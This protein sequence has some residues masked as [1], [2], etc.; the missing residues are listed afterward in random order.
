MRKECSSRME[1]IILEETRKWLSLFAANSSKHSQPAMSQ[2]KTIPLLQNP[3]PT[4]CSA[5]QPIMDLKVNEWRTSATEGLSSMP[6]RP[7]HHPFR[8]ARLLQAI[9]SRRQHI[10][11]RKRPKPSEPGDDIVLNIGVISAG[12]TGL[13]T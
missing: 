11:W 12:A 5:L 2:P 6:R 4:C 10:S 3:D 7:Y 8:R 13:S 1:P 9:T